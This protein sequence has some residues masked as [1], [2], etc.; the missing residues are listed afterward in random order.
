M[1][2]S[3]DEVMLETKWNRRGKSEEHDVD[4]EEFLKMCGSDASLPDGIPF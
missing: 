3:S 4:P 2:R 1:K